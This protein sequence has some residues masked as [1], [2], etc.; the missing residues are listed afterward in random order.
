MSETIIYQEHPSWLNF[1]GLLL[2]GACIL[3]AS[4]NTGNASGGVVISAIFF[5]LA[6]IGRY[7]SLYTITNQRV[8]MRVGL[9]SNEIREMELRSIRVINVQQGIFERLLG[10]GTVEIISVAD[11]KANV[12][13]QGISNPVSI[14]E[15]VRKIKVLP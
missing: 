6:A 15:Q 11:G 9:I 7:R 14:K 10:V 8:I 1:T 5:I 2:I 4:L 3:L 12:V 13:F